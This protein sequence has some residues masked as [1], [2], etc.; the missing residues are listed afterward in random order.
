[1]K[2]VNTALMKSPINWLTI[3]LMLFFAAIGGTLFLT[4]LNVHPAT[5]VT[6]SDGGGGT[7][8]GTGTSQDDAVSN[9]F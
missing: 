6:N 8:R 7:T 2:L 5:P 4:A 3:G 1:M 9:P